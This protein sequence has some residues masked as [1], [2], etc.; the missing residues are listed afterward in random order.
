VQTHPLCSD[1][2][3]HKAI[4]TSPPL[5]ACFKIGLFYP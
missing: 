5:L 4:V 1:S 3:T 2:M